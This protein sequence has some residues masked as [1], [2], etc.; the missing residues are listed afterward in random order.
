MPLGIPR[1]PPRTR[2]TV[3]GGQVHAS[4]RP[5]ANHIAARAGYAAGRLSITPQPG[6]TL[7]ATQACT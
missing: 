6:K 2:L 1:L 4:V 3:A 5:R 7:N